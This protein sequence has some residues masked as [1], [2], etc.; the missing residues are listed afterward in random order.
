MI[1]TRLSTITLATLLLF[2]SS[3]GSC[4]L[5]SACNGSKTNSELPSDCNQNQEKEATA[6]D[7]REINENDYSELELRRKLT[8]TADVDM[9]DDI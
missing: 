6:K 4:E 9:P 8:T 3:H 7:E 1:R 5:E 2:F